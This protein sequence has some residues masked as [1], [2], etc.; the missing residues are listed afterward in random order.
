MLALARQRQSERPGK[1]LDTIV[2]EHEVGG[3]SVLYLSDVPLEGLLACG[4]VSTQPLPD[5]TW[6]WVT[7][8]PGI[9]VGMGL[10]TGLLWIIE[11][12]MA[13]EKAHAARLG[14]G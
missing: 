1:Y 10:V 6:A 11:R 4:E 14:D 13:A 7:K 12:R 5:L 3:T 2:G 8:V 9:G